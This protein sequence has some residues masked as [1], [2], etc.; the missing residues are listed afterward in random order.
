MTAKLHHFDLYG[1]RQSKYDALKSSSLETIDWQQLTPNAPH[2]LFMPQEQAYR[3]EYEAGWAIN[4]IFPLNNMGVTTG[5][6]KQYVAFTEEELKAQHDETQYHFIVEMAYRCFDNRALYFDPAVLARARFDFMRHLRN[7]QNR[8]LAT[9]RRPRNDSPNNFFVSNHITGKE[10]VSALDNTQLFPLWRY[11]TEQEAAMGMKREANIAPAFITALKD[12][13]GATPT[14][15]DIFHY[16]YAV[17]HAPAYRTRYA[18]FLKTDFPR[19]P[20]PPDADAFHVLAALGAKL[21][22]LHLLEAPELKHHGIG[23][24]VSGDHTVKKMRREDR[25]AP[26]T[27]GGAP[28]RVR[29]NDAEYFEN[30]PSEAWAFQVGGYQPAF[31]WLDDRK[32][33]PLTADDI[34]HYRR[35]IAAMRE[36]AAL[37]PQVDAAFLSLLP[38]DPNETKGA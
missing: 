23:F 12:R 8:V 13:I 35:I 25:Y 3:E 9:V 28:G 2:Y 33:R 1:S 5:D 11:P 38:P 16:A 17:F 32:D 18:A 29:L 7:P 14:P 37:L 19:L 10:Y 27:P 6:A 22:A 20:L 21:T 4:E 36:T 30:V 31:K 24:P 15:E 34:T 26:P